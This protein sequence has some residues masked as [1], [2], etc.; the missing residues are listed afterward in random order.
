MPKEGFKR[1]DKLHQILRNGRRY[2]LSKQQIIQSTEDREVVNIIISG[3]FR[4]YLI[5]N[6]GSLG[7]MIIYGPE[8]IFPVTIL[9]K[10]LFRQPLY[11]G[12][13]THFYE[14]MGPAEVFT[15]D[16][17]ELVETIKQD[18]SLYPELL[19]EVG[20]HLD[21]CINSIENIALRNSEK[22]IAHM[23]VYFARKFGHETRE[24]VE[25]EMPLTHQNIGEILNITRETVS[26]NI[27][28]LRDRGLLVAKGN[29]VMV[30]PDLE[31]LEEE[32]YSGS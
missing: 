29:T 28:G 14:T 32:S 30:V 25:I 22:R 23:L 31:K 20:R 1:N 7:A 3:Y 15:V 12:Q 24:G 2:S 27:K 21:F 9:Y 26:T 4:K 5:T 8:D 11:H 10:K 13:E 17:E 18:P 6:D 16:A 19:Q